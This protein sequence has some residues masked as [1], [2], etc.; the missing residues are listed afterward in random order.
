MAKKLTKFVLAS[1]FRMRFSCMCFLLFGVIIKPA[2]SQI[3]NSGEILRAGSEDASVLIR[4]YLKPFGSGFGADLNTGWFSSA[5][6]LQ[7]FGFDLRVS[8][9]ASFVP[10]KDQLFDVTNLN[11]STVELLG[12]PSETPTLFG[13]NTETSTLG[14]T[15]FNSSSQQEEE[16][17]SF[18]MPEGS[19]YHF[20][21]APMAQLTLGLPGHSQVILRYSPELTIDNDYRISVFGIGGMVGLN[22]LLFNSNLPVDLSLQA[23][24]M[25]LNAHAPFNVRPETNENVENPYPDSH[26]DG[27]AISFDSNTFTANAIIGKKFSILSLFGGVGYQH[28][29]TTISINGPYPVIVP[30]E[31]SNNPN[32]FNQ[33]I[34]S[35]NAPINFSL[36]GANKMHALGGLQLKVGFISISADYTLAKYSTFRASVGIVFRS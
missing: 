6:P 8:V 29:T 21:P 20:V 4:E 1:N 36:D 14:S 27:Q 12:G 3:S 18:D 34:Q 26:W 15:H 23:G 31:D 22:Q 35:I 19:G 13:D 32:S 10:A 24:I 7:T 5:R 11:L 30:T 17:F 28:A 9:S 16:L 2:Y 25:D 33:E